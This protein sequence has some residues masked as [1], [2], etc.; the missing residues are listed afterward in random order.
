MYVLIDIEQL[1]EKSR[2]EEF[3]E[4]MPDGRAILPISE[5]KTMGS[6][7]NVDVIT[8]AREL[9]ELIRQQNEAGIGQEQENPEENVD[10]SFTNHPGLD[11]GEQQQ[12]RK[13]VNYEW[14]SSG[15]ILT[16]GADGRYYHQRIFESGEYSAGSAL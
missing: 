13:E 1:A 12:T 11:E 3:F 4:K 15:R 16:A 5:L 6:V 9:K 7:T 10:D 2:K 14:N 8:T